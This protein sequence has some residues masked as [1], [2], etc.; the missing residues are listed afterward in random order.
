MSLERFYSTVTAQ[1]FFGLFLNRLFPW[2]NSGNCP[3]GIALFYEMVSPVS[4][5]TFIK[6]L[7]YTLGIS[8]V[9]SLLLVESEIHSGSR[10]PAKT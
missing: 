3:W 7:V 4:K 10:E 1:I 2:A 9:R 8:M 6:Q 5:A